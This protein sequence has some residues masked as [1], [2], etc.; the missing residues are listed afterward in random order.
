[1]RSETS[2]RTQQDFIEL[3]NQKDYRVLWGLCGVSVVFVCFRDWDDFR[4]VPGI[5]KGVLGIWT[6][7][8]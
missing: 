3:N 8:K 6:N 7:I 2:S 5:W 1:M 4:D